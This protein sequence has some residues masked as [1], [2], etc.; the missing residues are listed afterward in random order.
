MFRRLNHGPQLK[1]HNLLVMIPIQYHQFLQIAEIDNLLREEFQKDILTT[2]MIYLPVNRTSN[3]MNSTI[4]L[5]GFNS[6]E[7]KRQSDV[8]ISRTNFSLVQLA[9]GRLAQRFRI[10]L[11]EDNGCAAEK[12]KADPN[13]RELS[14]ILSELG[15]EWSL[16][17]TQPLKN[18]YDVELKKQ[19]SRFFLSRASSGEKELLTYLF[20]IFALNVRDALIMVDEPEL[21]LHPKWQATLLK[22]FEDYSLGRKIRLSAIKDLVKKDGLEHFY[23]FS[24]V[25]LF[26]NEIFITFNRY[27]N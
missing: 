7:Q 18:T 19:G 20:A 4:E 10:L 9:I 22:L 13:L 5:S 27:D 12:F 25:D 3:P 2:P 6:F 26:K 17:C 23:S 8:G 21:H 24:K 14:R 16:V 1:S 15:Y 11:E